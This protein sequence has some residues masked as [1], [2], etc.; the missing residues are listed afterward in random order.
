MSFSCVKAPFLQ[1]FISLCR[2]VSLRCSDAFH[3]GLLCGNHNPLF[4]STSSRICYL[5][6]GRLLSFRHFIL[7]SIQQTF[8]GRTRVMFRDSRSIL[9][10]PSHLYI[11][12]VY[13]RVCSDLLKDKIGKDTVMWRFDAAGVKIIL[14][15]TSKNV[16][17]MRSQL[18]VS[19]Q[20]C[21]ACYVYFT[22]L[23]ANH[24][25]ATWIVSVIYVVDSPDL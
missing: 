3:F 9:A 13:S 10:H 14:Q 25:D 19:S 17:A 4:R 2:P 15:Y 23:T 1:L 21:C 18:C 7:T 12:C 5:R 8:N 6:A 20:L 11:V 16:L 22:D 24:S